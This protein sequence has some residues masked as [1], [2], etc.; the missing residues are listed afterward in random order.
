MTE[1]EPMRR[2]IGVSTPVALFAAPV[3]LGWPAGRLV[4][5]STAAGGTAMVS[6]P[7]F[8]IGASAAGGVFVS[9]RAADVSDPS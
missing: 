9:E 8:G 1:G 6:A 2:V 4:V 3:E 7:V 5:V